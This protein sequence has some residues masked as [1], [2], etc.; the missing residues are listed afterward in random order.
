MLSSKEK[1]GL[2]ALYNFHTHTQPKIYAVLGSTLK[3]HAGWC[4][5][6]IDGCWNQP[7]LD[8]GTGIDGCWNQ[9]LLDEG[10]GIDGCWNQPLLDEG[11]GWNQPFLDE[12]TGIDGTNPSWMKGL[13]LTAV[14]TNLDEG[15]GLTAVGTNP[16]W[17]KGLVLTA[18]GTNPC[19]E[20]VLTDGR[21]WY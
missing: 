9:P 1:C 12:G 20:L 4:S 14:G 10:A 3:A 6:G 11:T 21:D 2:K 5:S 16:C 7:L 8:E 13:V 19:W 15:T 17:M 18:V